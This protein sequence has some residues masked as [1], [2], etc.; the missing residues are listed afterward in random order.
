MFEMLIHRKYNNLK[1]TFIFKSNK[2]K[3]KSI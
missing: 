1:N 3:F 2:L